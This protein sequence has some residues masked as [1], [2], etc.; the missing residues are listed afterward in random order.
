M[1]QKVICCWF[2]E[3]GLPDFAKK[4]KKKIKF[5]FFS[6][7]FHR[8]DRTKTKHFLAANQLTIWLTHTIGKKFLMYSQNFL[9]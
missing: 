8:S 7:Y 2:P 5:P 1:P 3:G 9:H 4:F 6:R